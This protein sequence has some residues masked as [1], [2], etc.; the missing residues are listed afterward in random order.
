[1]IFRRVP[2]FIDG[3]KRLT[4]ADLKTR[5]VEDRRIDDFYVCL[6]FADGAFH[7]RAMNVPNFETVACKSFRRLREAQQFFDHCHIL[8]SLSP[9]QNEYA[10][11]CERFDVAIDWIETEL[12]AI[13]QREGVLNGYDAETLEHAQKRLELQMERVAAIR[14]TEVKPRTARP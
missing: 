3:E 13:E 8:S 7:V 4:E 1:M 14:A 9:D 5:M 11:R 10:A 6:W 12:L 2:A